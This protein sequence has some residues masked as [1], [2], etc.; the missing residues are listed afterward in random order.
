[1][2]PRC[3]LESVAQGSTDAIRLRVVS[4]EEARRIVASSFA[5]P[6]DTG[7]EEFARSRPG[8]AGRDAVPQPKLALTDRRSVLVQ[9]P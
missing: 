5:S 6:T 3:H 1:M 9:L 8:C 7:R 2:G 4:D